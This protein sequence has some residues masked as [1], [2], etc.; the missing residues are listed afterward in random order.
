MPVDFSPFFERYES[1]LAEVDKVFGAIKERHPEC[2]SCKPG[3]D[4]CCHAIF[5]L[6]LIE[7]LHLNTRFQE[8]FSGMAKSKLLERADQADREAHVFKRKIYKAS[9]AGASAREILA[10]ASKAKV[11]CPLLNAE[12]NCD[13]YE[14][15]PATCRI[16]GAPTSSGGE[17]HTCGKSAFEPGKAYTTVRMEKIQDALYTLSAELVQYMQS[18]HVSLADVFVPVSMALM[19]NYDDAYLGV[20]KECAGCGDSFTLGETPGEAAKKA[21]GVPGGELK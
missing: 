14:F 15:R 8:R 21:F 17:T 3:C 6:S 12:S 2:V 4:D 1:L 18:K 13:L 16:Y 9:E 11:R 10:E 20:P 7:A 19:N 5:D